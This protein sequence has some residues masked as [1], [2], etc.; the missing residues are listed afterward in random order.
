MAFLSRLLTK[1]EAAGP[2]PRKAQL[3]DMRARLDRMHRVVLDKDVLRHVLPVRAA[4]VAGR[5]ASPAA[6]ARERQ[7]CDGA[8]AYAVALEQGSAR[9]PQVRRITVDGLRWSAPLMRPD[10]EAA[11]QRYLAQQ[12]FPYRTITQTREVAVGGAMIDIGANVGR[13]SIPRV[14]LGDVT[15]AYCAEPDPLNYACLVANVVDNQL[16]GLVM[17]DRVAIGAED[18]VA[19][20]E[21][22]STAGGH[23]VIDPGAATARETIDVPL[24]TLDSWAQRVGIDPADLAFVKLDAQGSEVHVLRGAAR[25]LAQAHVAWQIEVDF[26]LLARRGCS[27]EDL[28]AILRTH[29]THFTDLNRHAG[30]ARVRPVAELADALAYL[31]DV[32]HGGTDVLVYSAPGLGH[33]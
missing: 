24:L 10:D 8:P 17:P 1:R 28:F 20:L 25:V 26:P 33:G 5:S 19:R 22:R 13:M 7:F 4:A 9:T 27:P 12:D 16:T 6:R 31:S 2:D 29:F 30:G 3:Q 23:T 11:V 18:G 15:A 32:R 14:I 21:R